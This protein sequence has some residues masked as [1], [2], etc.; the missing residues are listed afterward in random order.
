MCRADGCD[1]I[2]GWAKVAIIGKRAQLICY[3]V[4]VTALLMGQV[5]EKFIIENLNKAGVKFTRLD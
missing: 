4:I 2:S 5:R 1:I 3:F